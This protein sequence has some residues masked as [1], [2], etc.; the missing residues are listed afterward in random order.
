MYALLFASN[1]AFAGWEEL[2]RDNGCVFF[3]ASEPDAQGVLPVRAECDWPIEP[4]TL[5]HLLGRFADHDLYF[6]SIV[7]CEPVPGHP[8]RVWQLHESSGIPQREVV[9]QMG[10]EDIPGGKRFTWTR[11][12]DQSMNSG[13]GVEV[14]VDSGFWEVV[15]NGSGGSTIRYELRYL[16]GGYAPPFMVRWFLGS[17][18]QV[19][20]G[21]LRSYAEKHAR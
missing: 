21:Q 4:R 9:L 7:K 18:M 13:R 3:R 5:H 11:A 6:S 17:G 16:P 12:E 14:P 19:F 10:K 20:V 1:I 8:D 15:D 2:D